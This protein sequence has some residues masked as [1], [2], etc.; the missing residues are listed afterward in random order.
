MKTR[1]LNQNDWQSWKNLRLESLQNAPEAFASSFA[2]E[3]T[4]S[5]Q[6]FQARLTQHDIFGVFSDNQLVGCAGFYNLDALKTKHRGVLWGMYIKPEYRG[7]GI[8]NSLV[9]TV[10]IHARSHVIQLHVTCVTHNPVAIKLYQKHGFKIYGTELRALKI[11]DEFYD[12]HLMVLEL[13]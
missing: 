8:A 5:N 10:I 7:K 13:A 6:E 12:E 9:E 2:E 11:N 4:L 3:A 1:L